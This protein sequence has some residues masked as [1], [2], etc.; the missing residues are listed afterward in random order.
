M[1]L[2]KGYGETLKKGGLYGAVVDSYEEFESDEFG[3][4]FRVYFQVIEDGKTKIVSGAFKKYDN[5]APRTK[6]Y[7]LITAVQ[8]DKPIKGEVFELE[9]LIGATVKILVT[10]KRKNGVTFSRVDKAYPK[11]ITPQEVE[12]E[13]PF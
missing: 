1:K 11:N 3:A 5:V 10:N 13:I 12:D 2:S 8:L 7:S 4:Y 6:L 9:D